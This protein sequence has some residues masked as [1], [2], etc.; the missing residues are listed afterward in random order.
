MQTNTK[1]SPK[2]PRP[3]DRS[4][5]FKVALFAI[6]G[7]LLV[8]LFL[9]QIVRHDYYR[10]EALAEHVKKFEIPAKRGTISLSDGYKATPVV[11]NETKYLVYADPKFIQDA[12]TA[13]N[14]L[15]SV[16]GGKKEDIKQLLSSNSRYVILA[17]KID[18]TQSKR[19]EE[20]KIK[21][22]GLKE[23]SVRSYPQGT[24]AAHV[25]G[26]VNDDGQGQYGFEEYYNEQLVGKSG[27]QKIITDVNGVPLAINN[28]SVQTQPAPGSDVTL[29][30]D[31]RLQRIIE[32]KLKA[33]VERTQAEGGSAI[34][35]DPNTGQVKAMANYPTFDPSQFAN[36]QNLDVFMNTA[37]SK[38]WEPG[39]VMKPLM[40]ATAMQE[41]A[42]TRNTT[43][44][45]P[46]YKHIADTTVTN[47]HN[48]GARTM[49]MDDIL[50]KSLNTG[51]V[52][53]IQSLGGGQITEAARQTWYTYLTTHFMFN[54][55]TGIELASE[56]AGDVI[57]PEDNGAGINVTY[58]N[59]TFGQGLT[60]TPL[61]L[62]AA[63]SALVNGGTYYQPTVIAEYTKD[64]DAV[65][66]EP[67]VVNDN[68][69]SDQV[70]AEVKDILRKTLEENNKPALRAGYTLGAKSGTAEVA[71]GQGNYR[72]D[73][74]NGAYVGYI[75]GKKLEY[76][77]IV[78][79]DKPKT[80]GFAS[81]QA[82][83][84]W[85]EMSNEIISSIAIEPKGQ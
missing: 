14:Q 50:T 31:I 73:L 33:G 48:Y 58:A 80:S 64:G 66:Q 74:Y 72:E 75:E 3:F 39:S 32:E 6:G 70:S 42:V 19:T 5:L 81:R 29:T 11:L 55:T 38:A 17:K 2:R 47:A 51:A 77:M 18:E 85:A 21:G 52:Q 57:P 24:V 45:D 83:I 78:R 26:F 20:L 36:Q 28:D 22:V 82:A 53:L 27:Q 13:A 16:V 4:M 41:G 60:V 59:M 65:R 40:L 12:D 56:Q 23:M 61:Q 54:K 1:Q 67:K 84:V 8:Q 37:I 69:V 25:L 7:V 68:V 71:D 35:L 10:D 9:V 34:L 62:V 43:Y 30:L 76:V 46:G 15:Q 49:T 44:F 79:L 63:Y